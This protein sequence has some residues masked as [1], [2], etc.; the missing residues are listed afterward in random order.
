MTVRGTT[1]WQHAQHMKG[2]INLDAWEGRPIICAWDICT[3]NGYEANKVRVNTAAAGQ[4][5]S[6]MQYVFCSEKHRDY[7]INSTN[8]YGYLPGGSHKLL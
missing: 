5:P 4:A 8:K 1:R 7:W 2:V 3:N 6:Y